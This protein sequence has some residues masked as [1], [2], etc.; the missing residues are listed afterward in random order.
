MSRKPSMR[1]TLYV[2]CLPFMHLKNPMH[3]IFIKFITPHLSISSWIFY[4]IERELFEN[5]N[6]LFLYLY[7]TEGWQTVISIW[8]QI[9]MLLLNEWINGWID[10]FECCSGNSKLLFLI[11]QVN[12]WWQPSCPSDMC[13]DHEAFFLKA[14]PLLISGF[15][16]NV[17][18]SV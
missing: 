14:S 17:K 10:L 11:Y 3:I 1:V 15:T 2:R 5:E 4:V 9:K 18:D 6:C 13:L 12:Y 16:F 8:T 7:S